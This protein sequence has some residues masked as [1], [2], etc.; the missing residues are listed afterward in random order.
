MQLSL[1]SQWGSS[2]KCGGKDG[3]GII[4]MNIQAIPGCL[5][6]SHYLPELVSPADSLLPD[7]SQRFHSCV[8]LW[9]AVCSCSST[10]QCR[11]SPCWLLPQG[12]L[13]S[14][15]KLHRGCEKPPSDNISSNTLRAV[16]SIWP[17]YTHTSCHRHGGCKINVCYMCICKN[18]SSQSKMHSFF[19]EEKGLLL[20]RCYLLKT[21]SL[22]L[23]LPCCCAE[24]LCILVTS[25]KAWF[26][27][28]QSATSHLWKATE[29]E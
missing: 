3:T 2:S 7:H 10:A 9:S 11:A 21:S 12:T 5:C 4:T 29:L 18:T 15:F 14:W 13:Q 20:K 26:K 8:R 27:P 6:L 22:S 28:N 19:F 17:F 24:V 25:F 1:G 16:A 23:K